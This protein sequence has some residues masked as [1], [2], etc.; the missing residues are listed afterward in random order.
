MKNSLT[1]DEAGEREDLAESLAT[2]YMAGFAPELADIARAIEL[3]LNP[4]AIREAVDA[5][6]DPEEDT[7]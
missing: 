6:Y 5:C 2:T 4:Q 3:G 1:V 7:L